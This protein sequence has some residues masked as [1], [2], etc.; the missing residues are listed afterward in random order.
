VGSVKLETYAG[1]T[2]KMLDIIARFR[3]AEDDVIVML[4]D[5]GLNCCGNCAAT[6]TKTPPDETGVG[7]L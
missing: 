1:Q 6:R 5:A 4:G 7:A 3:L 2:V